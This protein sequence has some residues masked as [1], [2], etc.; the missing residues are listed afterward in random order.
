MTR[1]IKPADAPVP[2]IDRG[3]DLG[4]AT[5]VRAGGSNRSCAPAEWYGEAQTAIL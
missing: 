5:V 3:K 4:R 2:T 1:V